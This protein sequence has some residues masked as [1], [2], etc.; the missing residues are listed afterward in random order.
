MWLPTLAAS[1]RL[2]SLLALRRLAKRLR[3]RDIGEAEIGLCGSRPFCQ[4]GDARSKEDGQPD[5]EEEE[6]EEGKKARLT[7]SQISLSLSRAH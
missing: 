5:R 4:E 1:V 2:G 3:F 7:G 6:E